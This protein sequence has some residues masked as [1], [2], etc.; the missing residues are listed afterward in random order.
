M[1]D[2]IDSSG[3]AMTGLYTFIGMGIFVLLLALVISICCEKSKSKKYREL[4]SDMLI[5]GIIKNIAVEEKV[6]LLKELSEFVRI[7]KKSKLRLKGLDE[8]IE[9]ELKEKIAKVQEENLE[10]KK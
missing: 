3:L 9:A 5:V 1:Y 7:E 2:Y 8:V 4:M 10:K 6:D